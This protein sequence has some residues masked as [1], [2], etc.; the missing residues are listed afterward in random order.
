MNKLSL[1]SCHA[2]ENFLSL[3]HFMRKSSPFQGRRHFWHRYYCSSPRRTTPR[4]AVYHSWQLTLF[5]RH[6]TVTSS[7]SSSALKTKSL[8]DAPMIFH[9]ANKKISLSFERLPRHNE[10]LAG[11]K[12]TRITT[13]TQSHKHTIK[14]ILLLLFWLIQVWLNN[15]YDIKKRRIFIRV[16]LRP[17]IVRNAGR[18]AV[19]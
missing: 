17:L 7:D 13:H 18:E 12:L 3:R 16:I 4:I 15:M 1:C 2:L 9:L 5:F 8:G 11:Q 10:E 14:W 19:E 6:N